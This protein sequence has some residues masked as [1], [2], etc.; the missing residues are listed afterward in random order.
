M[1]MA[2]Q[3]LFRALFWLI[4]T[5]IGLLIAASLALYLFFDPN[6]YKP[7]ISAFLQNQTGLPLTIDGHMHFTLFP[8]VGL[9]VEKVSIDNLATI[10][11]LDLKVPLYELLARNIVIESLSLKGANITLHQNQSYRSLFTKPT[12]H[13][14]TPQKASSS[15]SSSPSHKAFSLAL[16]R[17]DI[18][19]SQITFVDNQANQTWMI[20]HLDLSGHYFAAKPSPVKATFDFS[21]TPFEKEASIKG[22]ATIE[23]TVLLNEQKPLV[24]LKTKLSFELPNTAWERTELETDLKGDQKQILLQALHLHSGKIKTAGNVTWPMATTEPITFSLKANDLDINQL[25]ALFEKTGTSRTTTKTKAAVSSTK[26]TASSPASTLTGRLIQGDLAIDKVKYDQ[27]TLTDVKTTV[28]KQGDTLTLSPFSA[29]IYNGKLKAS[30]TQVGAN[31]N[32]KGSLTELPIQS[33]LH[34]LDKPEKLSGQATIDFN[35]SQQA[36]RDLEGVIKCQVSHGMIDGIDVNY[37][38]GVAQSLIKKQNNTIPDTKQTAFDSLSATLL[39][40][41]NIID[42]NDLKIISSDFNANA[43]GSVYLTN[44]TLAYKLQANKIYH[45]G[46][47]HPNAYPLAIRI[48][49]P[50]KNPKIEPDLD[51]YLKKIADLEVK[52]QIGKLLGKK[53]N[54]SSDNESP[55]DIGSKV[56]KEIGRGLKKILKLP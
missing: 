12:S 36:H 18:K 27:Y 39:L 35:L 38:I 33:L 20:D 1:H 3:S 52:K 19:N 23:G 44:Q 31:S 41:D 53:D 42:N 49:G 24:D 54:A 48:K 22:K 4:A 29:T 25:Q 11:E 46:R 28:R 56:E 10:E 13:H 50:I 8:W 55:L 26:S 5:F 32:F 43:E 34:A 47:E 17:V 2:I 37:Y 14:T 9:K 7:Q 6:N 30:I 51:V 15:S 45:D 16:K 21:L 40:H